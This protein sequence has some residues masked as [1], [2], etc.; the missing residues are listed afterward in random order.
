[1]GMQSCFRPLKTFFFFAGIR[2]ADGTKILKVDFTK[3]QQQQR[4]PTQLSTNYLRIAKGKRFIFG[5]PFSSKNWLPTVMM[6]GTQSLDY[7]V[8]SERNHSAIVSS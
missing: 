2:I 5:L 7:W 8:H 3:F 6:H 4:E 1:M